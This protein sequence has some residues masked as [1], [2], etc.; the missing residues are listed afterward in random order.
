[1]EAARV[2]YHTDRPVSRA[3]LENAAALR[4][5]IQ[6]AAGINS[7]IDKPP[8]PH[9]ERVD[10]ISF[11][12]TVATEHGED[13]IGHAS[14]QISVR[15]CED[16]GLEATVDA[17]LSSL[18]VV[19]QHRRRGVGRELMC[20]IE[21][22]LCARGC[23]HLWTQTAGY[24]G[25]GFYRRLGYEQLFDLPGFFQ[26]GHGHIGFQLDLRARE[27]P[28][29]TGGAV[30]DAVGAEYVDRQPTDAEQA[31]IDAGFV[32]HAQAHG[33]FLLEE[34][35][36]IEVVAHTVEGA[37][38]DLSAGFA[39]GLAYRLVN[40][41]D[42]ATGPKVTQRI[43]RKDYVLTDLFVDF[44]FRHCGVGRQLLRHLEARVFALPGVTRIHA[45][46]PGTATAAL[47]L[48]LSEG[49]ITVGERHPSRSVLVQKM[50]QPL[51]A[52]KPGSQ[53]RESETQSL[54]LAR[55]FL[56]K[57]VEVTIDRPL[58]SAH[59]THGF[60]YEENYGFIA[61][62]VAPDGEGLDAYFLGEEQ[63][64]NGSTTGRCIAIVHRR[65]DDDDSLVVVRDGSDFD[66]ESRSSNC[67]ISP[68]NDGEIMRRV[69][70]QEQWFDSVVIR[71]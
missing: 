36:R 69:R 25:H 52:A 45:W 49:Y 18:F 8:A 29:S 33:C 3:D 38:S 46:V 40:N 13:F 42:T 34:P 71:S 21:R 66:P 16:T 70:F 31:L 56:G 55:T 6:D 58:G 50:R 62:T 47:A 2:V 43:Y 35:E 61:G 51:A 1:M 44:P 20:R 14:A 53:L 41:G 15:V 19:A 10:E 23:T 5:R 12:A 60:R 17:Y 30:H 64:I 63:P 11:V 37:E 28:S 22:E 48:V 65:D 68:M 9:H 57:H 24:D 27:A 59:P 4:T 54:R 39:S 32:E 26:S 7:S 67:D